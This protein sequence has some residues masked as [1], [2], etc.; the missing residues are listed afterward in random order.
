MTSGCLVYSKSEHSV[1]L[2]D[3]EARITKIDGSLSKP[4]KTLA[5]IGEAQ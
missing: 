2:E 4:E 3:L 1:D 5:L